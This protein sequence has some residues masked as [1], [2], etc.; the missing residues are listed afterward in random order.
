MTDLEIRLIPAFT[1]NYIYA[2]RDSAS[3]AV[4]VVDP[5]EAGAAIAALERFGWRP[6]LILLTHHHPDHIGG[7]IELRTRFGSQVVGALADQSRLPPL[8]R[9]VAEGDQV[10][11][12]GT[13]LA[14]LEVPGHTVGHIAYVG[15]GALFSGDTL[16]SLGCGRMFEGTA[17][18]M[19]NSL[20]KL[21]ALPDTLAIYCGH[22][23][24]AS[25]ARFAVTVDPDNAALHR[26]IAEVTALRAAG[27]PT[28]PA[29]LADERA[30]NPFLRADDP[31]VARMLGLDREPSDAVA[32]PVAVFAALRQRKD[33]F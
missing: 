8:D 24:T 31:T 18:Q 33:H 30:T 21:R 9:A 20:T 19:W 26:R 3:G 29:S 15:G 27:R 5:G 1:D 28:I 4:A 13:E 22:E 10:L 32:D 16:F 2:L 23:Y 11:L 6:D 25:N 14:V 17:A 12:G 7:A